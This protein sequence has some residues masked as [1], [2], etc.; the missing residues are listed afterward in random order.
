MAKVWAFGL[1]NRRGVTAALLPCNMGRSRMEVSYQSIPVQAG[2]STSV[3]LEIRANAL[4]HPIKL[5]RGMVG[6]HTCQVHVGC[7]LVVCWLK[8]SP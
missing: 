6:L 5:G 8:L 2:V 3:L 4:P 1:A 7:P